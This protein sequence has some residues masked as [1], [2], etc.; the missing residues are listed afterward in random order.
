MNANLNIFIKKKFNF[1]F[2]NRKK[3]CLKNIGS[4]FA[5]TIL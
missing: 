4:D 1:S 3:I 2:L 5:G